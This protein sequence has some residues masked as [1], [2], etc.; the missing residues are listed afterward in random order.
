MEGNV[1][2]FPR[3]AR[4]EQLERAGHWRRA[5]AR[6]S[7]VL[8]TPS[9]TDARWSQIL[10]RQRWCLAQHSAPVIHDVR[11]GR[12]EVDNAARQVLDKMGQA[13]A[14]GDAFR[15]LSFRRSNRCTEVWAHAMISTQLGT[16]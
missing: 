8:N 6:W 13:F 12:R 3:D 5:A 11:G 14:S 10:A 7:E 16:R 4:A 1:G 2:T 15:Q 9:L